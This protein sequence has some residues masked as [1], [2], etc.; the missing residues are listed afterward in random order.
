MLN[1]V[2]HSCTD[3]HQWLPIDHWI[4]CQLF[5]LVSRGF[6]QRA[7]TRFWSLLS[8]SQSQLRTAVSQQLL[9]IL[10]C[11]FG[12]YLLLPE[13][14]GPQYISTPLEPTPQPPARNSLEGSFPTRC[15]THS[16]LPGMCMIVMQ[17]PYSFSLPI[18]DFED[19]YY[20]ICVSYVNMCA[21]R[22]WKQHQMSWTW[23]YKSL[24]VVL[25]VCQERNLSPLQEQ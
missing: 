11:D 9:L 10:P 19:L 20:F 25:C 22:V 6:L 5:S 23:R 24:C 12:F 1:L 4:K 16:Q 8:S 17:P 21:H 14:L 13:H 2:L 3:S 7:Q 15:R 18:T